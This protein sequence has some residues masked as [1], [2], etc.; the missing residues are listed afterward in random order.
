MTRKRKIPE[1]VP[2]PEDAPL[3]E[4]VL[5]S[6]PLTDEDRAEISRVIAESKERI[7]KAS[8]KKRELNKKKKV[9]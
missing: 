5:G 6:S 9:A 4:G 3:P 1:D 7:R 2:Y 8:E